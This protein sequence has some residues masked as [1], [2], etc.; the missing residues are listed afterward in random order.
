MF[1]RRFR[2][3]ADYT[4]KKDLDPAEKNRVTIPLALVNMARKKGD[5][6]DLIGGLFP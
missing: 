1:V 3:S 2:R 6:G 5:W 4:Q